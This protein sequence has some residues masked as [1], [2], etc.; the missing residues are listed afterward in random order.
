MPIPLK[1]FYM[2]RHGESEANAN[3]IMAGNYDSP[4]TLRGMEQAKEAAKALSSLAAMPEI[5]IHS[6]LERAAHTARLLNTQAELPMMPDTTMRE[7]HVGDW[8]GIPHE[9]CLSDWQNEVDPPNGE[10]FTDFRL[11]IQKSLTSILETHHLPLIVCHGGVFRSFYRLHNQ[12]ASTKENA[13]L[14]HFQPDESACDFPWKI[15]LIE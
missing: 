3:K 13:K 9:K 11:R 12:A 5:I 7:H 6:T 4:L 10:S 2:I 15:T 1:P 8:E 14:Y